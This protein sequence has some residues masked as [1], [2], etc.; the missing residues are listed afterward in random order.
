MSS[1]LQHAERTVSSTA[2]PFA[3]NTRGGR[4]N[5]SR[6]WWGVRRGWLGWVGWAHA[7]QGFRQKPGA[8]SDVRSPS[9]QTLRKPPHVCPRTARSRPRPLKINAWS[10]A[11]AVSTNTSMSKDTSVTCE[12]S[13]SRSKHH[14]VVKTASGTHLYYSETWFQM[15][16][17]HG[18]P[19]WGAHPCPQ[20]LSDTPI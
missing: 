17:G 10:F 19:N 5:G 13:T 4:G 15:P 1:Q 14:E 3:Q 18:R 2:H 16:N 11:G 20:T 8:I 6:V 9:Q 7:F 12:P